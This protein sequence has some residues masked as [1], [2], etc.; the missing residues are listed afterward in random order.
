MEQYYH[1]SL[2]YGICKHLIER[3]H[4]EISKMMVVL[5][6]AQRSGRGSSYQDEGGSQAQRGAP[7]GQEGGV[8]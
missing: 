7:P 2:V 1:L 4:L 8:H 5:I 3:N 6:F